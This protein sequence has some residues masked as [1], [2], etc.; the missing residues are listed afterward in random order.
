MEDSSF[1][2]ILI[3]FRRH[4]VPAGH[5]LRRRKRIGALWDVFLPVMKARLA[6]VL[7][8]SALA[9]P[10][11]LALP[12][13]ASGAITELGASPAFPPASCP[14]RCEAVGRVSGYQTRQ[15]TTTNAYRVQAPGR[16]VA[17]TMGLGNPSEEQ[18]RFFTRQFGD[19]PQARLSVLSRGRGMRH[20][21]LAQS[22]TFKLRRFFGTSP[23]F[24]LRRSLPVRAGAIVAM[25][26]PTWAPALAVGL[27]EGDT[28][29][30]SRPTT[31][32]DDVRQR[33]AHDRR[34]SVRSYR[35]VY[36]TAR[37]LYTVSFVPDPKPAPTAR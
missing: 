26:V 2:G 10:A 11:W 25:T 33:A 7:G 17:F 28:W 27:G 30:A 9:L 37:L 5:Q 12:A 6:L 21:L 36:K 32:C 19:T 4:A 24:A 31:R 29:R 15:G 14:E 8:A 34:G 16:I 3:G 1:A 18:V 35:C 13:S 20:R 23:T 22:E